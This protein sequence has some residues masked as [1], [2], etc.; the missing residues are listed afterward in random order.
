MDTV[1]SLGYGYT[2]GWTVD[3]QDWTGTRSAAQISTTVINSLAPGAI[4]LMHANDAA[5]TT[6]AL[7]QVFP[8][9][10]T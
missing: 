1:G 10:I 4:Y 2:I 7:L 3:T 5:S 9:P 6:A 8:T